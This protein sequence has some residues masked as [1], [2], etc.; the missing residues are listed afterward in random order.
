VVEPASQANLLWRHPEQ[1]LEVVVTIQLIFH[2]PP[3]VSALQGF[4]LFVE[5]IGI[6]ADHSEAEVPPHVLDVLVCEDLM[7]PFVVEKPPHL[8]GPKQLRKQLYTPSAHS[9]STVSY[10]CAADT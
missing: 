6:L 1:G 10:T 7:G 9:P 3:G 2:D 8:K 5:G 4:E